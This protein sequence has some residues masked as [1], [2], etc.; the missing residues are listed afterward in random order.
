MNFLP[1]DV[2]G[3]RLVRR[4]PGD[5]RVRVSPGGAG[6]HGVHQ[7]AAQQPVGGRALQREG[8]GPE[9]GQRPGRGRHT[10]TPGLA[11]GVC[12]DHMM[13]MITRPR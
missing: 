7:L 2:H 10:R 9:H 13:E 3:G 5:R 11:S 6:A 1:E 4:G 12:S 8:A